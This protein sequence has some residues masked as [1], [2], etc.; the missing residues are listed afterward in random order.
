M[1]EREVIKE[2]LKQ[3]LKERG[4]KIPD[5]I[6]QQNL[7]ETFCKYVENDYYEWLKDNFKSF[8]NHGNPDWDCIKEL[9][10]KYSK[11]DF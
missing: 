8:F 9:I 4:I 6:S 2:F 3:E 10:E 11:D 7:V 1:L 5:D